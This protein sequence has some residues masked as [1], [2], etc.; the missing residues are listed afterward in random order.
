MSDVWAVCS[1]WKINP[2]NPIMNPKSITPVWY[3]RI[4]FTAALLAGC[5]FLTGCP[6]NDYT[7]ELKPTP[8]GMER[9]LTFSRVDGSTLQPFP[10]NELAAITS[11]Y[12]AGAIKASGGAYTAK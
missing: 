1:P 9:T 12:P 6:H 4:G 10:S 7:V 11:V 2:G 5:A 3:R 8:G